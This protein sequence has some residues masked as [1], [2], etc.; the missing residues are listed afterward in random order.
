MANFYILLIWCWLAYGQFTCSA[1]CVNFNCDVM[2]RHNCFL[3]NV[4]IRHNSWHFVTRLNIKYVMK[5]DDMW[6][7]VTAHFFVFGHWSQ[8]GTNRHISSHVS[9][10]TVWRNVTS[11]DDSWVLSKTIVTF[12]YFQFC[13]IRHFAWQF[14]TA[15]CDV[16]FRHLHVLWRH[17]SSPIVMW[18]KNYK[19]CYSVVLGLKQIND[20]LKY[21]FFLRHDKLLDTYLSSSTIIKSPSFLFHW[22]RGLFIKDVKYANI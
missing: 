4:K 5:C 21:F 17:S 7:T 22:L 12:F 14:V 15:S 1:S 13:T 8:F 10:L 3:K 9:Y 2:W 11:C 20:P 16:T 18:R 19:W 6:W